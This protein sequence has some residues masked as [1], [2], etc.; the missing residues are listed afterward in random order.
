MRELFEKSFDLTMA[1][2]FDCSYWISCN[3]QT[4]VGSERVYRRVF[5]KIR[6]HSLPK[7]ILD[8]LMQCY[9]IINFKS[10]D[11]PVASSCNYRFM[12]LK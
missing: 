12:R 10:L 1:M 11:L 3:S 6:R 7:H 9:P 5:V 2:V 8:S 4:E